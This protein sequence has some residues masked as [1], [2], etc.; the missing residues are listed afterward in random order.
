[1]FYESADLIIVGC[2]KDR[3]RQQG[4]NKTDEEQSVYARETHGS[5]YEDNGQTGQNL[6]SD[7][8]PYSLRAGGAFR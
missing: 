4:K 6:Y 8:F 2:A 5:F 7:R 1:M 3:N